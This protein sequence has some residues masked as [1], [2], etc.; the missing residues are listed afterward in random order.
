MMIFT[1]ILFILLSAV[2]TLISVLFIYDRVRSAGS[3]PWICVQ[4]A[5][6]KIVEQLKN[7]CF[8]PSAIIGIGRGG[9]IFGSFISGC[10]GHRPLIVVDRKYACT[11]DGGGDGTGIRIELPESITERILLVAGEVH[12]GQTMNLY[13]DDFRRR[14]GTKSIRRV[15]FSVRKGRTDLVDYFG[16]ESGK[17]KKL[18]WMFD[19]RDV[20][21]DRSA[22]EEKSLKCSRTILNSDSTGIGTASCYLVQEEMP[23][24]ASCLVGKGVKLL[25]YNLERKALCTV[26]VM[27][28]VAGGRLIFHPGTSAP[29]ATEYIEEIPFTTVDV[30]ETYFCT[31]HEIC[32]EDMHLVHYGLTGRE[33]QV[34]QEI[35]RGLSNKQ[36]ALKLG[37]DESTIKRHTHN[38]Y[39]KTGFRSRVELVLGLNLFER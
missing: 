10:F 37:V 28:T 17:D 29:E 39:E 24:T 18:P 3:I 13:Y 1:R 5:S 35:C 14:L 36:I 4:K 11:H 6:E 27:R 22:E 32:P 12:T 25:F 38:I 26:N 9:A 2:G 30:P 16:M 31:V 7:D 19:E 23:I 21:D 20:W 15:A 33:S 34:A 8:D